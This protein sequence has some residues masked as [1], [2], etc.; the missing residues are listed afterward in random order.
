MLKVWCAGVVMAGV[1]A[2]A[3]PAP[4]CSLVAGW[5]QR[6]ASRS[7]EAE[8]LFEYMD[9]NAEG[10]LLYG[11]QTMRG[12]SCTKGG[13]SMVI[14]VSDFGDADSAF[15]FFSSNRDLRVPSAKVGMGGQIIPRR[16]IFAKDRYYV[17]VAVNQEGDHTAALTAWAEA[18]EKQVPGSNTPPAALSWFP[19]EKQQ[20]LRLFPESVRGLRALKRGYA[21]IYEYGKAFVVMEESAATAGAA[22]QKVRARFTETADAHVGDEAFSVNDKYLGRLCFFRKGRYIAGWANVAEGRSPESLAAALAGKLP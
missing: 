14:D 9:G 18:L 7:Y 1:C 13:V 15:G 22:M 17:E 21:G 2:A 8:N 12:V 20:S 10:Y 19:S 16:A 6:G 4:E 3:A 11:F 5:T